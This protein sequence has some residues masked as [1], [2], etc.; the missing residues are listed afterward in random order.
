MICSGCVTI[1][2]RAGPDMSAY[3]KLAGSVHAEQEAQTSYVVHHC[4]HGLLYLIHVPFSLCAIT[5]CQ[6]PNLVYLVR[7]L[8]QPNARP[9][10]I[11]HK[12][13]NV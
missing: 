3:N 11:W 13:L 7:L 1:A 9:H 5:R 10:R 8:V 6:I 4:K 2:S 12:T